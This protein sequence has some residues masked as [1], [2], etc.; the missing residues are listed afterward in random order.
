MLGSLKSHSLGVAII[1]GISLFSYKHL[2]V[3]VRNTLVTLIKYF[4]KNLVVVFQTF[5]KLLLIN[6]EII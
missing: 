4:V 2:F 5:V 6:N 3:D 1:G